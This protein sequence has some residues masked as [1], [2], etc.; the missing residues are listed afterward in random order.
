M[1]SSDSAT[2]KSRFNNNSNYARRFDFYNM[3][4]FDGFSNG[5]KYKTRRQ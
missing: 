5:E 4:L 1:S 3:K 2:I